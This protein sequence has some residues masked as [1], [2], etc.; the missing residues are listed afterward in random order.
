MEGLCL[1]VIHNLMTGSIN[2]Q[3]RQIVLR[4]ESASLFTIHLVWGQ[5]FGGEGGFSGVVDLVCHIEDTEPVAY[6]A[7]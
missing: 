1:T 5:G 2:S 7:I 3:E 6:P 4:F